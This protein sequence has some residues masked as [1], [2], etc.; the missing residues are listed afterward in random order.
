M[1]PKDEIG[2]NSGSN[3]NSNNRN[4]KNSHPTDS[5]NVVIEPFP[6]IYWLTLP[7]LRILV[8][9]LELQHKNIEYETRLK[10]DGNAYR[11]M[12]SA[13][14]QYANKRFSLIQLSSSDEEFIINR[15]WNKTIFSCGKNAGN[16]VNAT[17]Q[18]CCDN[19]GNSNENPKN[20]LNN[21]IRGVAGIRNFKSVKCLH[22]HVAH[23]LSGCADN[24][25]G[26]WTLQDIQKQI[27]TEPKPLLTTTR[28]K[29]K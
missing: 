24:L 14:Q 6:T 16:I 12:E 2:D 18:D 19:F 29:E 20:N 23:Y 1:F 7:I 26:L 22:A 15:K 25:V 17:T 5:K 13:H 21:Q 27:T 28:V 10:N 9:K 8:S 3:N 4:E 11:T